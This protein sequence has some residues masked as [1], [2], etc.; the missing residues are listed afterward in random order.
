MGTSDF[1]HSF[2]LA[3]SFIRSLPLVPFPGKAG[4]LLFHGVPMTARQTLSPRKP[5]WSLALSRLYTPRLRARVSLKI[6]IQKSH[7]NMI[8]RIKRFEH[9]NNQHT[10]KSSI[11]NLFI[12]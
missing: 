3:S 9:N 12:L 10:L 11:E 6:L 7:A 5:R 2:P 4:Y 8:L 1:L